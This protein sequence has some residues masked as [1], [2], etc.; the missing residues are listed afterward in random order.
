VV[1]SQGV[2]VRIRILLL[3]C[4]LTAGAQPPG[5]NYDEAKVPK[6]VLP[7]PLVMADG[8]RVTTSAMWFE[9]RR[10]EL[11]EM[12]RREMYGRRP[13]KPPHMTF[14][15]ASVDRHALGGKA[16]RKEVTVLFTGG[17]DGPKMSLLVYLPADTAKPVPMFLGLNFGGNQTVAADP[18]I[19][20]G[21]VWT[22]AEKSRTPVKEAAAEKSRGTSVRQ[23][24]VEKI[25]AHGYGLATIYYGEIEPDFDGGIQY[26]VR[27][28]FL[29]AGQTALEADEWGAIGAWAWGLSRALD[30]LETDPQVDAHHV[31]V[32][33]HSRLGKTALWAGAEDTRFAMAISN[34]SGEGGAAL[35]RRI[36]GEQP[37]DLT[38]R[39][40]HWF[41]ANYKKYSGR[42][43]ALPFDQHE[44]IALMAPRP[45]YVATAEEDLWSDP[46]GQ[47]LAAAAAGPVYQLLG[48]QGLGTEEMPGPQQPIMHDI[49]YHHRTGQHDVTEYDWEQYLKFADIHFRSR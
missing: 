22:R 12:F 5:T 39:F 47:F 37:K 8:R 34:C 7:D 31:A 17:K 36:F 25:L 21:E 38:S 14:E 44:L 42:E 45:V 6:Y 46:K 2:N 40:P 33:G 20:L 32:M 9:R 26:G 18:G 49:G 41:D 48:K 10:P 16:E 19:H 43:S 3:G 23:W 1:G 29:K 30:Y 11:L 24:Q 27:P 35:S 15:P 4:T 28:L 13:G